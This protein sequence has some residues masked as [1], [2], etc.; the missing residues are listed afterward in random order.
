MG[1]NLYLTVEQP[2]VFLILKQQQVYRWLERTL[3]TNGI[4]GKEGSKECNINADNDANCEFLPGRGDVMQAVI[5]TEVMFRVDGT[6]HNETHLSDANWLS[7]PVTSKS[8]TRRTAA[9]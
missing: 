8:K 5:R 1:L 2:I 6:R 9:M 4:V 3:R 7:D